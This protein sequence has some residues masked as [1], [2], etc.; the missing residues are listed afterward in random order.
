M[1]IGDGAPGDRAPFSA[2][3]PGAVLVLETDSVQYAE[4]LLSGLPLLVIEIM[5]LEL[6]ELHPFAALQTLIL[7]TAATM[8]RRLQGLLLDAH[9]LACGATR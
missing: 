4:R 9:A 5:T 7:G 1:R 6:I 8:N 3:G 2:R